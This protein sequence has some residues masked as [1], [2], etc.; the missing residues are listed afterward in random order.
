M[1]ASRRAEL[2]LLGVTLAWGLSF[3]A[4][5]QGLVY[6]PPFTF[7]AARFLLAFVLLLPLMGTR[8]PAWKGGLLLGFLVVIS[9]YSQTWGLQYTTPTRSAFIT[10]LSVVFVPMFYPL[11]ARKRPGLLPTLGAVVA[12][13]GL[14]LLTDPRGEGI[15][16]GDVA[17]LFC[18]F[19]YAFYIIVLENVTRKHPYRGVLFVQMMMLPLFTLVPASMESRD[20]Q[21]G[22][23]LLGIVLLAA[24]ITVVTMYLQTRYQRDTTATKAAVIFTAEP[25]FAGLFSWLWFGEHMAPIQWVG[26]GVILAGILL[27]EIRPPRGLDGKA[28]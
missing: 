19:G 18:A 1:T 13:V 4:I 22:A 8:K 27:S 14:Y 7:L 25:V 17:T 3:P 9:H 5:K 15:N 23:P 12:A 21:W 16:R 20:V 11:L 10:G 2:A 24:L 6:A 28:A 26:G